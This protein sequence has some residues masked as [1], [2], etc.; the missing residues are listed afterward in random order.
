MTEVTITAREGIN[1][2]ALGCHIELPCG[3]T[4]EMMEP[5]PRALE[6]GES[7][8]FSAPTSCRDLPDAC[9]RCGIE[10]VGAG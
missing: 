4:V 10:A 7:Y 9:D 6:P 2:T 5:F 8:H 1:L 3:R